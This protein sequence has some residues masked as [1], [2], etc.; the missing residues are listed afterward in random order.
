M[1]LSNELKQM[2]NTGVQEHSAYLKNA[3]VMLPKIVKFIS[4]PCAL[5]DTN[6]IINSMPNGETMRMSIIDTAS[7]MC[8]VVVARRL[9]SDF[10]FVSALVDPMT[11]AYLTGAP[12][13]ISS[14]MSL[15]VAKTPEEMTFFDRLANIFGHYFFTIVFMQL[16]IP[17][18]KFFYGQENS[19][20]FKPQ[21]NTLLFS[22]NHKLIDWPIARTHGLID[23]GNLDEEDEVLTEKIDTKIK[24]FID[25]NKFDGFIIFSMSTYT[26]DGELE[27]EIMGNF[28][29][30]F[31]KFPKIGFIWRINEIPEKFQAENIKVFKWIPQRT[32]FNHPKA[33][34]VI[35]HCG[36]NS[37]LEAVNA[38][39]PIIGI[40]TMGDQFPNTQRAKYRQ[41]G[42]GLSPNNLTETTIFDA[43]QKIQ[44]D[45]NSKENMELHPIPN[46]GWNGDFDMDKKFWINLFSRLARD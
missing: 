41:I 15:I 2:I 4:L 11:I 37:F 21:E 33:M 26:N 42:V 23:I 8:A 46:G 24:N 29:S 16:P 18:A 19:E 9:K 5:N 7:V 17:I 25:S 22:N 20:L 12:L 44:L 1:I 35:T 27:H 40:P 10:V 6:L 34:A 32:L 14:T 38:G 28:S 3:L 45:P 36:Q 13:S 31:K 30:V 39:L 43:I